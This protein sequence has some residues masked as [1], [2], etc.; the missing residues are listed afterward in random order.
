MDSVDFGG[1]YR[2][3]VA[4]VLRFATYLTGDRAEAEEVA[5]ETFVRAWIASG[6]IRMET[7]K[8]Y[9]LSIA[10]NLVIERFRRRGRQ[11]T[12]PADVR[13]P[14][15]GP[16]AAAAGRDALD[17]VMRALQDM[18]EVN[19]AA[20]LMRADAMSYDDIARALTISPAAARVKVHRARMKL[21]AQGLGG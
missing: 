11:G 20:V 15:P 8:A 5:S 9:L 12:M 4:D 21:A 2:T 14:A 13:D 7:V 16:D 17:A 19:R 18:P 1:V 10:R 3:Y 6:D